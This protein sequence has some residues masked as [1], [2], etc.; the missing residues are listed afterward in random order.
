MIFLSDPR[1]EE[2]D[3]ASLKGVYKEEEYFAV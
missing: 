3:I 2:A 1:F